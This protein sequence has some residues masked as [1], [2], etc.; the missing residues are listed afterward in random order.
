MSAQEVWG[1]EAYAERCIEIAC[2]TR[3]TVVKEKLIEMAQRCMHM[4]MDE[5][6]AYA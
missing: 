5:E 1:W 4:A 6:D 3:D 2:Q